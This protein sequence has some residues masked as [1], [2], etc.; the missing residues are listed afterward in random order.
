MTPSASNHAARTHALLHPT[1]SHVGTS[2]LAREISDQ[3]VSIRHSALDVAGL[4]SVP[5]RSIG[6]SASSVAVL[7]QQ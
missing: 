1:S 4:A 7:L 6:G 3:A 2:H 5:R